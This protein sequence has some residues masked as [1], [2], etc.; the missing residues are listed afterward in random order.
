[1]TAIEWEKKAKRQE[2][3]DSKHGRY[4]LQTDPDETDEESI[5]EFYNVIGRVEL[6][7]MH[8]THKKERLPLQERQ[9]LFCV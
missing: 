1:V 3:S 8:G 7:I 6:F 9:P 5:W 2:M 4:L